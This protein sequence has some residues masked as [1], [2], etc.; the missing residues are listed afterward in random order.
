MSPRE[1]ETRRMIESSEERRNRRVDALLSDPDVE[2]A[3]Q[4]D[5][6]PKAE[7]DGEKSSSRRVA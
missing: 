6:R 2:A 1:E 5:Q 7:D 4:R 3:I